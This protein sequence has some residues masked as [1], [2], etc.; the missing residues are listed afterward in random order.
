MQVRVYFIVYTKSKEPHFILQTYQSS[1]IVQGRRQTFDGGG[2]EE[3]I[4]IFL[5]LEKNCKKNI[6]KSLQ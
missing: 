1:T 4:E 2:G 6:R 5:N 3:A